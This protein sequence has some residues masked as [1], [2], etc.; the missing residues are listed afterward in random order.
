MTLTHY[1]IKSLL[2][3]DEEYKDIFYLNN[4]IEYL[5]ENYSNRRTVV[6]YWQLFKKFILQVET[7]LNKDLYE[8]TTEEIKDMIIAIPT[9]SLR[10]KSSIAR[11]A[12]L[13]IDWALKIVKLK[14]GTNP[15]DNINIKDITIVNRKSLKDEYISIDKTLEYCSK[16]KGKVLD[17]SIAIL[18]L[19][20]LGIY[21]ESAK[22]LLD[23]RLNDI[24]V[25]N[26]FIKVVDEE[27][28]EITNKIYV[29]DDRI[30]EY[31][32]EASQEN[33][34]IQ[35]VKK[36]N[37][38]E[39]DNELTVK[40]FPLYSNDNRVIKSN[41]EDSLISISVLYKSVREIFEV[42]GVK[43][44]TFKKLVRCAMIDYVNYK[45]E[46]NGYVCIDDFKKAM[47]KFAPESSVSSYFNL[48][49]DYKL[50][51]PNVNIEPKR[52]Q[53]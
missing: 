21:G 16:A 6:T 33:Y 37:S 42:N 1:E 51:Y 27:T 22:S 5:S 53:D 40:E 36:K 47:S 12:S 9:S 44:I 14:Q 31:I 15:F 45:L 11:L 23:L 32:A 38:N 18:L 43:P 17:R 34:L 10:I 19:G 39:E 25:D 8:F 24:D 30:F 46:K 48:Q 7:D 41:K 26:G 13:Y 35:T 20:R 4:K 52:P 29:N 49:S 28:G 3:A 2:K 50:M